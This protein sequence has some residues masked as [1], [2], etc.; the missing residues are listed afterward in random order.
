MKVFGIDI[1]RGSVRSRTKRP[2]FALVQRVDGEEVSVG[3]VSLYRLLR[4]VAEEEPDIL[5]VDSVQ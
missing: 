4:T 2:H 1:I 3:E 5:A